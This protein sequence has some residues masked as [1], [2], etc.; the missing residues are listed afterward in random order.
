MVWFEKTTKGVDKTGYHLT[1]YKASLVQVAFR[2]CAM[3]TIRQD[4]TQYDL[5]FTY[6]LLA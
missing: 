2:K 6:P 1:K 3:H 5:F 4:L